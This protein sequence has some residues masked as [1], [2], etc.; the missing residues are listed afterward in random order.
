MGNMKL[1]DLF[2]GLYAG[3]TYLVSI[4]LSI[5]GLIC[6]NAGTIQVNKDKKD[7]KTSIEEFRER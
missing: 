3:L 1:F 5:C 4:F 2:R 7:E 6:Y